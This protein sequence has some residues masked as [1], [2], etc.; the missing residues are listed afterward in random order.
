MNH[1]QYPGVGN[2]GGAGR[3]QDYAHR[4][5]QNPLSR[6][7]NGQQGAFHY[8]GDATPQQNVHISQTQ[9]SPSLLPAVVPPSPPVEVQ[10]KKGFSLGNLA[11]LANLNEIKGFVDR[12]G[13]LD[14]I[15]TTITKVQ[16]VVGSITQMAPLAKVLFGKSKKSSSSE[17]SSG[18]SFSSERRPTRRKSR[19]TGNGSG[20]SKSGNAGRRRNN[21]RRR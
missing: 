21:K 15:L 16:K 4:Q 12:M 19:R 3:N 18:G 10:P 11:S 17:S 13:G 14:G 6:P 9:A 1:H 8:T 20:R 5:G 2:H 7:Y